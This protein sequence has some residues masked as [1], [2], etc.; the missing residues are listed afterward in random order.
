M[1]DV[2]KFVKKLSN[3][4]LKSRAHSI[5]SPVIEEKVQVVN[6]VSSAG[7]DALNFDPKSYT[8]VG[9]LGKGCFGRV[10]L[11]RSGDGLFA[12]K[13][14]KTNKTCFGDEIDVH[15]KISKNG[16]HPNIAKLYYASGN[17][18]KTG[19]IAMEYCTGCSL[20]TLATYLT[21]GQLRVVAREVLE[22]LS[23][24]ESIKV[25]HRDLKPDNI[26][27]G[28]NGEVKISESF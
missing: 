23:F 9:K 14:Q 16:D 15:L 5:P 21:E 19:L 2:P 1:P 6:S 8:A 3:P 12:L 20:G 10:D 26:I 7:D 27:I 17:H 28:R 18:N 4:F 25:I 22:A 13:Q 24:L 11:V